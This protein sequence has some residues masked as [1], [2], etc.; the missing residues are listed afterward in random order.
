MK[1]T[2]PCGCG[3]H[4]AHEVDRAAQQTE[5]FNFASLNIP[6]QYPVVDKFCLVDIPHLFDCLALP[7]LYSFALLF[8]LSYQRDLEQ[9]GNMI[10]L[11]SNCCRVGRSIT[12]LWFEH[13]DS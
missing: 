4:D 2:P 13:A 9:K 12:N 11:P 6:P 10:H 7:I 3:T 5:E 1:L 8:L